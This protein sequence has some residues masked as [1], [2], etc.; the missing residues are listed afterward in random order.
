MSAWNWTHEALA[1]GEAHCHRIARRV[2][3]TRSQ[4]QAIEVVET[5]GYG[6]GLF[7]DGRI[8]H[9]AAD[10][11]IYSEVMSHPAATLL[12]SC[13]VIALVAAFAAAIPAWRASKLD[14]VIALRAD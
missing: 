11:Y 12:V 3:S 10:E 7:L 4:F 8:Q 2:H 1:P 5:V 13:S 9:V 6:I 14:P